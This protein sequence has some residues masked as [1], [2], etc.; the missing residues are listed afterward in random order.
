MALLHWA[1]QYNVQIPEIDAEHQALFGVLNDL[2]AATE[3]GSDKQATADAIH[4]VS[5]TMRNHLR[6]EESLLE[7]WGY[8]RFGEHVL[9][10]QKLLM[11]LDALVASADSNDKH[12][13]E[14]GELNFI[15]NWLCSHIENSDKDYARF[16]ARKEGGGE[17]AKS[18]PSWRQRIAAS[19]TLSRS[20]M[21]ALILITMAVDITVVGLLSYGLNATRNLQEREIRATVESTALL[22]DHNISESVSKI[23]LTLHEIEDWLEHELRVKGRI[24]DREAKMFLD[25]RKSWLSGLANFRVTDEHGTILYGSGTFPSESTSIS[26][27]DHFIVHRENSRS[28]LFVSNPILTRIGHEWGISLSRRYNRQDGSFA[29]VISATVNIDYFNS[30]LS[31]ARLGANGVALLRDG[32]T[33]MIARYPAS[34]S[35]SQQIGTKVFS[36][37]LAQAIASGDQARSFHTQ[38]TGD[39]VERLNAYRRLS[40]APFH[41]VVGMG[42][43]DYLAQW[44]S[45]V[46]KAV[47]IVSAFLLLSVGSVWLLWRLFGLTKKAN[48]SAQLVREIARS[49]QQLSEAHRIARLG[50]IELNLIT[51]V[52]LLGEGTQDMLGINPAWKSGSEEDVFFNVASDDRV[53][54]MDLLSRRSGSCFELELRI[55]ARTLHV[56]GEVSSDSAAP[57]M[58][59]MTL[60]DI[61]DR[62]IA[63]QERAAMIERIAESDRMEALGTLAGG[64]AHEINTP[65]QYVSDNIAFMSDGISSLLDLAESVKAAKS[66]EGDLVAMTKNLDG[67]DLDFLKAELPAA[68]AQ[69][70]DG[71]LRIAKIVQAIKEFSYPSSKLPHPIDLN[72]LI[73]VVATVTRNQWKYV[74]ELE[75]DLDPDLPKISAIEGEIN[76]VLVNL[77]V[78]ATHAIAELGSSSLGRIKVKTQSLGDG[79]ELTV[80][81]SGVGIEPEN[82]KQIFELFFTTKAPGQGTGQGLAITKAIIHRHGGQITAESDPGSGA[83]FRIRLPIEIPA[84]SSEDDSLS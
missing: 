15:S 21:A 42:T 55:G 49:K 48:N 16:V 23:D 10:H 8:P 12:E 39:G 20:V 75:F 78:N 71:T 27:R 25:N 22:L 50:F 26:D 54:L 37:E 77:L 68:A 32:D 46:T 82:L 14:I 6:H 36:D 3:R 51:G 59:V 47:V 66:T 69:A 52:Y 2:W 76:Q 61:T 41:L 35:P 17:I 30:L 33:G 38:R 45:D 62:I 64:I 63:E 60:Q 56:L 34:S 80:R 24:E 18:S 29:G 53:R 43:E 1:P 70:Q 7:E 84:A 73:D 4:R 19:V 13:L 83:C 31:A 79:V 57:A 44:H 74:A 65:T 72:H 5:E 40:A 67:L 9:E 81:D 11:Q 58:V 28:G